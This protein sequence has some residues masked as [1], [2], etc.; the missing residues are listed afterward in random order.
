MS[1][2]LQTRPWH[3][4][5]RQWAGLAAAAVLVLLGAGVGWQ[6]LTTARLEGE[7]DSAAARRDGQVQKLAERRGQKAEYEEL[8]TRYRDDREQLIREIADYRNQLQIL[9]AR[10]QRL[11]Q[12]REET[13][14]LT[15]AFDRYEQAESDF[16]DRIE[17]LEAALATE[18]ANP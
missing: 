6:G 18:G 14:R 8:L 2:P 10:T 7:V 13:G 11:E 15:A 3:R 12:V 9:Q 5:F 4:Q 17:R 1:D 16:L